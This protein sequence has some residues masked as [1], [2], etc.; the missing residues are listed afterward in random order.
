MT[1]TLAEHRRTWVS[2]GS[3]RNYPDKLCGTCG[4]VF[5]TAVG[6]NEHARLGCGNGHG[7]PVTVRRLW[8]LSAAG[9]EALAERG[10]QVTA[11][12]NSRRV[13]CAEC[14]KVST[15]AAIGVHQKYTGHT[16]RTELS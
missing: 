5:F 9:R 3:A 11:L 14:E 1:A 6:L 16:G 7:S 2:T 4:A 15:P 10:R 12:N 13:R 8:R